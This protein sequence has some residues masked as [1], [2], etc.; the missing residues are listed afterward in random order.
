MHPDPDQRPASSAQ[1]KPGHRQSQRSGYDIAPARRGW[2]W[3]GKPA[4]G[5]EEEKKSPRHTPDVQ[6]DQEGHRHP[7]QRRA[8][9]RR[10]RRRN[11]SRDQRKRDYRT[12]RRRPQR[13]CSEEQVRAGERGSQTRPQTG[14]DR[15]ARR[16]DV[17]S[18]IALVSALMLTMIAATRTMVP[19]KSSMTPLLMCNYTYRDKRSVDQGP[20]RLTP[21]FANS[22]ASRR[23]HRRR[24]ASCRY[25]PA[26][27]TNREIRGEQDHAPVR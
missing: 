26:P 11:G 10:D 6:T 20:V 18:G 21:N 15:K 7:E 16:C 13:I 9:R 25:A 4:F 22:K 3:S 17:L 8:H 5:R 14:A 27:S 24:P 2:K 19:M 1:R 23:P 12:D